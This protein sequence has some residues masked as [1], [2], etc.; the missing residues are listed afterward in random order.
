MA[1]EL[2]EFEDDDDH[3]NSSPPSQTPAGEQ[4]TPSPLP[5]GTKLAGSKRPSPPNSQDTNL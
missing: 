1:S 3:A 2:L 5:V 4:D